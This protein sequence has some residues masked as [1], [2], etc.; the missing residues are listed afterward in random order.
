MANK[1]GIMDS[2]KLTKSLEDY[3]EMVLMLRKTLGRVRVKDLAS[4]LSV[5]MPSVA[6]AIVHLKKQKLVNQES[7]GDIELTPLGES[8]AKKI[9][10]RHLLL[11]NFLMNIGV[12]E[13]V[14]NEEAC[15][16]EHILSPRTLDCI[17]SFNQKIKK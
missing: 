15:L 1:K 12:T 2:L 10:S 7:Y 4:A 6:K 11:K 16:M 17:D 3:L 5:K 13:E 9:L 14:A 8:T